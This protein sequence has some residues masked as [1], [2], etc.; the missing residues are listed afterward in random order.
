MKNFLN[1]GFVGLTHLGLNYLA[2]SSEKGFK[3]VGVDLDENKVN[4]LRKFDIDYKEP[5]LRKTI[6]QK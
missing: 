2:A 1:I 6:I 5:N 3:V 4:K